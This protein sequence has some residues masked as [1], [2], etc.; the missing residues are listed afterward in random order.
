[1]MSASYRCREDGLP[2]QKDRL[3][4]AGLHQLTLMP[5]DPRLRRLAP[6]EVF[7]SVWT[8]FPPAFRRI[9]TV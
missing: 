7:D 1:M 8:T 4:R 6:V 9:C 5:V 3:R 2:E